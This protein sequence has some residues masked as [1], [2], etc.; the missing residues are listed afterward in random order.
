MTA[1]SIAEPNSVR[2]GQ[3]RAALFWMLAVF[4]APILVYGQTLSFDFVNFDDNVYVYENH[5]VLEGLSTEGARWAFTNAHYQNYHPLTWVS[6]MADVAMFGPAPGMHH[7]VNVALHALNSALLFL[8]LRAWTGAL[9]KSAAVA[10]LFAV[11]PLHVESVAW[12]SQRKEL[13]STFCLFVGLGLY[14]Q[15][16]RRPTRAS[17]VAFLL[18]C[19]AAILA[20]PALFVL[21]GLLL[22]LD[23]WPLRRFEKTGAHP[24]PVRRLLLEKTLLTAVAIILAV[25]SGIMLERAGAD[26]LHSVYSWPER[27]LNAL[28]TTAVY[29]GQTV[30]PAR[31]VPFYPRPDGL[32]T[33]PAI[34]ASAILIAA[35]SAAAIRYRSRYPYL[36]TGWGWYL[37]TVVPQSGIAYA[38]LYSHADRDAYLPI[39]GLLII[40]VWG[41]C[42]VADRRGF[43]RRALFST[44]VV[45]V[46]LYGLMAYVQ[47]GHWRNSG[48]LWQYTIAV[49]PE[50]ALANQNLGVL[51]L[52]SGRLDESEALLQHALE[53]SQSQP[54]ARTEIGGRAL[55]SLGAIASARGEFEQASALYARAADRLPRD[56]DVR[57][58]WGEALLAARRPAEAIEVLRA[59][60]VRDPSRAST[61]NTLAVAL[62][63]QGEIDAARKAAERAVA[64][65]PDVSEYHY[66]VALAE[67]AA[68]RY[69]PALDHLQRALR[70]DSGY[71]EALQLRAE[72]Y[73]RRGIAPEDIPPLDA[74]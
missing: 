73:S 40:A 43:G 29:V 50:N 51:L 14:T 59:V 72:I 38:G 45:A 5:D 37:L 8:L 16:V 68:E 63:V 2:R 3:S 56:L 74:P 70:I 62:L 46:G 15:Y 47:T 1:A 64:L 31:L 12:I 13:L 58:N 21:P 20:K 7:A 33:W 71:S 10:L 69:D 30:W 65:E 18:M 39:T 48:A 42:A 35:I 28:V 4:A 44:A 11:H 60:T 19:A 27:L 32:P 57:S 24:N 66:R 36:L 22:L 25:V 17:Q 34:A 23:Y 26:A 53:F 41:V 6:H 67:F 9:G 54:L 52:E 49:M 61:W 55:N